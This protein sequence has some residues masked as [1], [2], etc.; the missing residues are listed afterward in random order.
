MRLFPIV[1]ARPR[2][3]KAAPVSKAIRAAGHRE[4]LLHTGQHYDYGMSDV[5]FQ[6]MTVTT[7]PFALG[8]K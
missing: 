5:F 8:E 7:I 4:I 3:I 2:F 6:E 1:G